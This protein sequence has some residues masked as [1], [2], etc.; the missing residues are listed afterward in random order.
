[1]AN[2]FTLPLQM[3]AN[4]SGLPYAGLKAYFY[5]AGSLTPQAVYQDSALTVSH[6]QPVEANDAGHLPPIWL[7]PDAAFDYRVQLKNRLGVL[8]DG[9]DI[10]NVPRNPL[11][12]AQVAE[13]LN[14]RTAAENAAGV[15]PTDY[16]YPADPSRD[17]RRDGPASDGATDDSTEVERSF[18]AASGRE[19]VF[20][21]ANTTSYRFT[22]NLET[23]GSVAARGIGRA[24]A[25]P[26][27][28]FQF[29]A[30]P[31]ATVAQWDFT[32]A[33][34]FPTLENLDILHTDGGSGAPT[35]DTGGIGIALGNA[36]YSRLRDLWVAYFNTGIKV[37]SSFYYSDLT[38]VV[39]DTNYTAGL[40]LTGNQVN[41]SYILGGQYRGTV[42]GPGIYAHD[43][44][45]GLTMMGVYREANFGP[46]LQASGFDTLIDIGGYSESNGTAAAAAIDAYF[47]NLYPHNGSAYVVIGGHND[48]EDASKNGIARIRSTRT[49]HIHIGGHLFNDP[50]TPPLR[51]DESRRGSA[52]SLFVG[53]EYAGPTYTNLSNEGSGEVFIDSKHPFVYF[54]A[55]APTG[56]IAHPGSFWHNTA[57]VTGGSIEIIGWRTSVPGWLGTL[58]TVTVT[59]TTTVGSKLVNVSDSSRNVL[60]TGEYI[61]IAGVTFEG[62]SYAMI[63]ECNSDGTIRLNR[64]CDQ[65]VTTAAIA[66]KQGSVVAVQSGS[67]RKSGYNVAVANNTNVHIITINLAA[68]HKATVTL[69]GMMGTSAADADGTGKSARITLTNNA[70]T[71]TFGTAV[72]WGQADASGA[73]KDWI[74]L[75]TDQGSGVAR[76]H[77]KQTTGGALVFG[78]TA[79]VIDNTAAA[80]VS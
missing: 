62:Q 22:G 24:S 71:I 70:G 15:T 9:G 32:G 36:R 6:T 55:S 39:C 7:N 46:G 59:A 10:D 5:Q 80:I 31:G 2:L 68:S 51:I 16:A 77:V 73:A 1:V 49:K 64:E 40:E 66:Y 11:T 79:T 28:R 74:I 27:T 57:G 76:I 21:F 65:L 34:S 4:A 26:G 38:N 18:A 78:Y 43:I 56:L 52:G 44:G 42:N 17:A 47:P 41:N 45:S 13:L 69:D 14:P 19:V 63:C 50:D 67:D 61:E 29:S 23:S 48:P 54:S 33:T 12:S 58:P 53:R 8:I 75:G 37:S 30:H 3:L 25:H 72:Y 35:N 60:F 20:P